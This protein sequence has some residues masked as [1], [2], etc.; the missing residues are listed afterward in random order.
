MV[1]HEH[2]THDM[3]QE[4]ASTLDGIIDTVSAKHPL[5]DYLNLLKLNGRLAIVGVPPEPLE[6]PSGSLVFQRRLIGGSLIGGIRETQEM[7]VRLRA[8]MRCVQQCG[9]C[10]CQTDAIRADGCRWREGSRPPS[11]VWYLSMYAQLDDQQAAPQAQ[12]ATSFRVL[13]SHARDTDTTTSLTFLH[14]SQDFCGKHNIV[15][16]VEVINADY[17]NKAYERLPKNDVHYRFVIDVQGSMV[18]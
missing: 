3:S 6:L 16:D 10:S 2:D 18:Q 9:L 4:H 13:G 12:S 14:C 8:G 1:D 7:L 11:D 15:S 5:P 17:V